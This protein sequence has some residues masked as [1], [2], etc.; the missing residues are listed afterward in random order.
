MIAASLA[1]SAGLSAVPDFQTFVLLIAQYAGPAI[2]AYFLFYQ[3]R[4][5]HA[6]YKDSLAKSST[7]RLTRRFVTMTAFF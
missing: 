2:L 4:R 1:S 6:D 7:L 5:V 3:E